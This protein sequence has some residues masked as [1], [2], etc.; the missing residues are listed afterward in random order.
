MKGFSLDRR[1]RRPGSVAKLALVVALG[2]TGCTN[3]LTAS[4]DLVTGTVIDRFTIGDPLNCAAVRDATCQDFLRIATDTAINKRGIALASIV[5]H[6]FY[7]E[8][9]PAGSALGGPPVGVVVF[10]LDNGSRV[11]VGVYCGV[12]PCQ[13]VP[14]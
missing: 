4:G 5:G 14:R 10:D 9:I 2:L 13:V 3:G 12:G 7:T 11:A 6:R 1:R 8:F